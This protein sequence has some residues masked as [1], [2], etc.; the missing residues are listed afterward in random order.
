MPIKFT[1]SMFWRTTQTAND[2]EH[3]ATPV[4]HVANIFFV[5]MNC[6]VGRIKQSFWPYMAWRPVPHP[7][8]TL[9]R[10]A[11][12]YFLPP[13]FHTKF[14][15]QIF[16]K[17]LMTYIMIYILCIYI[18]IF[19]YIRAVKISA[20]IY[21][22]IVAEINALKYFNAV[23]ATLFTSSACSQSARR[24]RVEDGESWGIVG[25]KVSI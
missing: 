19:I 7:W 6:L 3:S 20:L 10:P 17:L 9:W 13:Q 21:E 4:N 15:T 14:H 18:Y 16:F 23:N 5:F 12:F 1:P 24:D 22:I 11:I 25:R 8:Y 2:N